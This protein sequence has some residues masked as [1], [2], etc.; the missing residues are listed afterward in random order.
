MNDMEGGI[1]EVEKEGEGIH[2]VSAHERVLG[3]GRLGSFEGDIK[4]KQQQHDSPSSSTS[5]LRATG[6]RVGLGQL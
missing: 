2:H 4:L 1:G 5:S 3:K 6:R